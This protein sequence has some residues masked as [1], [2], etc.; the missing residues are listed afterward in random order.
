MLVVEVVSGNAE[1]L[2]SSEAFFEIEETG[3][4]RGEEAELL[5]RPNFRTGLCFALS[6]LLESIEAE[7]P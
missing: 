7:N 5:D 1:A 3:G 4:G 2:F 6:I